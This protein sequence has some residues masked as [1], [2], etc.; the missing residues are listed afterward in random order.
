MFFALISQLLLMFIDQKD[1][2][3]ILQTTPSK[4][5]HSSRGNKFPNEPFFVLQYIPEPFPWMP[6]AYA[7]RSIPLLVEPCPTV[8]PI[9]LPPY[10][11][12]FSRIVFI[13][14]FPT[15]VASANLGSKNF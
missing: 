13:I 8:K 15:F 1:A 14:S 12:V 4:G 3:H 10:F 7:S 6:N 11:F 9:S 2:S 5:H